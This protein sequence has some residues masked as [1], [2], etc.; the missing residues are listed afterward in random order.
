MNR[1]SKNDPHYSKMPTSKSP[2]RQ[3]FEY[4]AGIKLR[5]L[6]D[7]LFHPNASE[8][9]QELWLDPL[10]Q[11]CVD[12]LCTLYSTRRP[13]QDISGVSVEDATVWA[14]NFASS[15]FGDAFFGRCLAH[16][17][18]P[19]V[20]TNIQVFCYKYYYYHEKLFQLQTHKAAC[21]FLHAEATTLDLE[22][23]S[24]SV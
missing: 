22:F 3:R 11:G 16:L 9:G 23:G 8:D 15:S 4:C 19:N 14:R 5:A 17:L 12:A 24:I 20:P 10:I 7:L 2:H 18:Q 21:F 13:S 1:S 6:F